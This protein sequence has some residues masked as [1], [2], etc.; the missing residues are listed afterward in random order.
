MVLAQYILAREA[1]LAVGIGPN[2]YGFSIEKQPKTCLPERSV[3]LLD[4]N[5]N[6]F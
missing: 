3:I 4:T 1:V 6:I 2:C 5:H